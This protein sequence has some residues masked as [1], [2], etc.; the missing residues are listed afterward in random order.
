[1]AKKIFPW[2]IP[3][4]FARFRPNPFY[5]FVV[6]PGFAKG[7]KWLLI[8]APLLVESKLTWCTMDIFHLGLFN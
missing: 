2:D 7:K 4:E 6:M 1:M 5:V 3:L 8:L